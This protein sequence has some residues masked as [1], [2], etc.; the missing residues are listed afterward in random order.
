M[1][2]AACEAFATLMESNYPA[3]SS[4]VINLSH[5]FDY[6]SSGSDDF[7]EFTCNITR[8]AQVDYLYANMV[9]ARLN[10]KDKQT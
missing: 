7:R 3:T 10:H 9:E 5:T 8:I 2:K 1:I 6:P 4:R